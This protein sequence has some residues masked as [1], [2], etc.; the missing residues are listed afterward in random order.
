MLTLVASASPRTGASFSQ[1]NTSMRSCCSGGAA[2]GDSESRF[3]DDHSDKPPL[4]PTAD[5]FGR[6]RKGHGPWSVKDSASLRTPAGSSA[7]Q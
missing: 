5:Y 6:L 1:A 2:G 3:L 7:R 4:G